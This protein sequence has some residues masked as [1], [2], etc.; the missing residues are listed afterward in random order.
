M[1]AGNALLSLV[2][3]W[4]AR[5]EAKAPTAATAAATRNNEQQI[6]CNAL[7][8]TV[9]PVFIEHDLLIFIFEVSFSRSPVPSENLVLRYKENAKIL[10]PLRRMTRLDY[11]ELPWRPLC[12]G[13]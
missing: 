13:A 10:L 11:L 1:L 12:L 7:P 2:D 9:A 8:V 5:G 4:L 3:P 6:R